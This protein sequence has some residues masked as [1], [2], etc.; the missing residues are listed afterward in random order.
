MMQQQQANFENEEMGGREME[1]EDKMLLIG[2]SEAAAAKIVGVG[3]TR[4]ARNQRFNPGTNGGTELPS[5]DLDQMPTAIM[6]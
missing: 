6:Q 1:N 4:N 2:G 5:M 3:D